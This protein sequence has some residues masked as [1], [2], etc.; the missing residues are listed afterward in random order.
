[1]VGADGARR[2]LDV[3]KVKV[4]SPKSDTANPRLEE[5][6]ELFFPL[7]AALPCFINAFQ[8]QDVCPQSGK[9]GGGGGRCDGE[10]G[11]NLIITEERL[12][13]IPAPSFSPPLACSWDFPES[14]SPTIFC[15]LYHKSNS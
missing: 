10:T 8:S 15:F 13:S 6:F 7:S 2:P 5:G 14:H 9:E 1:M 12:D 11:E 4:L 3:E